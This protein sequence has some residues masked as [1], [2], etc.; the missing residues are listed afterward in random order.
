MKL[1]MAQYGVPGLQ[2]PEMPGIDDPMMIMLQQ[3]MGMPRKEG[4]AGG[5]TGEGPAG[6]GPATQPLQFSQDKWESLWKLLHI[7]GALILVIWSLSVSGLGAIFD[8]SLEQRE[9]G[10]MVFKFFHYFASMELFLQSSR[11]M[12]ER[13]RP[14]P[15]S[16]LSM[17]GQALPPKIGNYFIT[18]ARYSAIW[19]TVMS[20]AFIIIFVL[21]MVAWWNSRG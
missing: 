17:L 18:V 15:G 12:I 2:Q 5:P 11:F 6:E 13:G 19:T 4:S 8:G 14:P 10:D 3:M 20:D 1:F 21:G 7:F 9:T 16:M